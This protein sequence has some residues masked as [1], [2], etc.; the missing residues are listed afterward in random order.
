MEEE[1]AAD[2][3]DA[4]VANGKAYYVDITQCARKQ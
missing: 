1:K 2:A 4:M 3:S